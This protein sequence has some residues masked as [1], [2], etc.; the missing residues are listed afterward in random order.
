MAFPY[1]CITSMKIFLKIVLYPHPYGFHTSVRKTKKTSPIG[2]VYII[3]V[4][5]FI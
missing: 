3:C 1:L 2:Y 4:N 5:R